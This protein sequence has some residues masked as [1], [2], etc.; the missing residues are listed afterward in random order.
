MGPSSEEAGV[1]RNGAERGAVSEQGG[2]PAALRG[3]PRWYSTQ[4]QGPQPRALAP[5]WPLFSRGSRS[6]TYLLHHPRLH[7]QAGWGGVGSG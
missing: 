4:R 1:A 5:V 2:G 7:P 6:L 3:G